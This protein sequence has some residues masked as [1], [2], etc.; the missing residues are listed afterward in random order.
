MILYLIST[1]NDPGP[2]ITDDAWR[3]LWHRAL[4]KDKDG[5]SNGKTIA[6]FHS[7]SVASSVSSPYPSPSS[8]SEGRFG[9][10]MTPASSS[11]SLD[12]AINLNPSSALPILAKVEFDIDRRKAQWYELWRRRGRTTSH[13]MAG[14]S[15]FSNY[16]DS[17]SLNPRSTR[18]LQLPLRA[19]STSPS[20]A[21]WKAKFVPTPSTSAASLNSPVDSDDAGQYVRLDD[22]EMPRRRGPMRH[23]GQF[24]DDPLHGVFP[25]DGA[26]W[27]QIRVQDDGQNSMTPHAP[28]LMIGGRIGSTIM[29]LEGDDDESAADDTEDVVRLWKDKHKQ[30]LDASGRVSPSASASTHGGRSRSASKHIPPP[31]DLSSSSKSQIP[32]VEVAPPSASPSMRGHSDLPYL[33]TNAD[34]SN[35]SRSMTPMGREEAR[36]RRLDELERRIESLSPNSQWESDDAFSPQQKFVVESPTIVF[37]SAEAKDSADRSPTSSP[38]PSS[39]AT[40][41]SGSLPVPSTK[42]SRRQVS[43][44]SFNSIPGAAALAETLAESSSSPPLPPVPTDDADASNGQTVNGLPVI[45]LSSAAPTPIAS[46]FPLADP[47]NEAATSPTSA[48]VPTNSASL[49]RVSSRFSADSVTS[50]DGQTSVTKSDRAPSMISVKGIR[51]L[52]RKSGNQK[53]G[54]QPPVSPGGNGQLNLPPTPP[55]FSDAPPL[56]LS[57]GGLFSPISMGPPPVPKSPLLKNSFSPDPSTPSTASSGTHR[58]S[59]SGL[60]PFHFDQESRYPVHKMPSPSQAFTDVVPPS[61]A[62][63]S[64]VASPTAAP[65]PPAVKKG[66]LKGWGSKGPTKR[67]SGDL[68][69]NRVTSPSPQGSNHPPSS[70]GSIGSG[71]K[72]RRPSLTNILSGHSKQGSKASISSIGTGSKHSHTNNSVSGSSHGSGHHAAPSLPTGAEASLTPSPN[73]GSSGRTSPAPSHK[74]TLSSGRVSGDNPRTS[75]TPPPAAV[76]M[77]AQVAAN[78]EK[79]GTS[80]IGPADN[81]I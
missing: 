11:T 58:R 49:P 31:L 53:N 73:T 42:A 48:T 9:S 45:D 68:D 12:L 23:M 8:T 7:R 51:S 19:R 63:E 28:D 77:A 80:Y 72:G 22:D 38:Q 59:D 46:T 33:D 66:I 78:R 47:A 34:G 54:S 62:S 25:S 16:T 43:I 17:N 76:A 41:L 18:E 20:L 26:T 15:Q 37:D 67:T 2:R 50:E 30:T 69:A 55:P 71:K 64:R 6:R 35:A 61:A 56:P 44:G 27:A 5:S 1:D 65:P 4:Q 3:M 60:D 14:S 24:T 32:H 75:P 57:A 81:R 40:P 74:A 36:S 21:E 39:P 70:F 13:S 79:R 52:W 10:Q 29:S